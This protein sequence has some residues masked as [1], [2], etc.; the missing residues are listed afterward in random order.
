MAE[1]RE[2]YAHLYFCLAL[3]MIIK[4][5]V[6]PTH[7]NRIVVG[8]LNLHVNCLHFSPPEINYFAVRSHKKKKKTKKNK[9]KLL[10]LLSNS[11]L[12]VDLFEKDI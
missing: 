5:R 6:R 3:I 12:L 11:S 1:R 7:L 8:G 4:S 9:K 10:L 2:K